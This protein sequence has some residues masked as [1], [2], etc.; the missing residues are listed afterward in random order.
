[1][2]PELLVEE[3]DPERVEEF[4]EAGDGQPIEIGELVELGEDMRAD[5]RRTERL[6]DGM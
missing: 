3:Y 2:L 4:E 1:V 5:V 6:S